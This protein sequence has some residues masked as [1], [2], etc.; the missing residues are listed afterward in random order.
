M[1][2]ETRIKHQGCHILTNIIFIIELDDNGDC[3]ETSTRASHDGDVINWKCSF[4]KSKY[5]GENPSEKTSIHAA[6][7]LQ[8][9]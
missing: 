6:A 2:K 9:T 4:Y 1:A 8:A 5:L 7:I 3:S